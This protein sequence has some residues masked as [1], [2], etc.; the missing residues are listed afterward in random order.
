MKI[1]S[2]KVLPIAAAVML[3]ASCGKAPDLNQYGASPEL[4]S[5]TR[6][7]MPAVSTRSP[8]ATAGT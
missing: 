2:L 8:S 1:S 4:P 3:L 5:P 6:G 7:V